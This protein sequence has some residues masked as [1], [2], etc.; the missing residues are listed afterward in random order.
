MTD[1][2]KI[3][4]LLNDYFS[5]VFNPIADAGHITAND[6]NNEIGNAHNISPEKTLHNLEITSEEILR[7]INDMKTNTRP[8]PD[9]IYPERN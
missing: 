8:G 6:G 2:Q 4:G 9:N 5:S 7:A 1:D 3:A